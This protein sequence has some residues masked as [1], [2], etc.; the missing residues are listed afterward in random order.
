M[1]LYLS[2]AAFLISFADPNKKL[3]DVKSVFKFLKG[4]IMQIWISPYTFVFIKNNTVKFL[5][6]LS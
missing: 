6:S 3:F 4:A 5:H 1:Y 2:G